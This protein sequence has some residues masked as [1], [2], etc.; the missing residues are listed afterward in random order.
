MALEGKEYL[1]ELINSIICIRD[2]F[3][4][5]FEDGNYILGVLSKDQKT[6]DYFAV[7]AIYDTIVD[8]DDKIKYS[9]F[10]AVGCNLSETLESYNPFAKQKDNELVAMYHIENMIYRVSVLWDLLAQLCN[11]IYHTNIK[12][13]KIYC[14]RYFDQFSSGDNSIDIVKKIKIYFDEEED[15]TTDKNPWR[16]NH[17]FLNEYRNQM[18]HRISPS[19]T[20]ISTFG[21]SL[22]PP[23]MYVLHR[24]TED[25]YKVSS[26]LCDLINDFKKEY[27]D[28][29]PFD[30]VGMDGDEGE[31]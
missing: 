10:Q 4:I 19:L 5:H 2:A 3:H 26:F 18:T 27:E 23:P 21:S 6:N 31:F 25:Y 7:S 14:N 24:V 30:I 29:V 8:L 11:I 20:T 15:M 1:E 17:K 12:P 16:G 22:C 28:W 13:D 9:F